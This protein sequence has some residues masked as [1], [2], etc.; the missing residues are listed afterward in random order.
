MNHSG[1]G[2]W[3][4]QVAEKPRSTSAGVLLLLRPSSL[5]RI[6]SLH[7]VYH[8]SVL[9]SNRSGRLKE[10][11]HLRAGVKLTCLMLDHQALPQIVELVICQ[12]VSKCP[13]RQRCA[14]SN[15]PT[16]VK[17][18]GLSNRYLLFL[19]DW[20]H[21]ASR[22]MISEPDLGS[23]NHASIERTSQVSWQER[24]RHLVVY[25]AGRLRHAPSCIR[26][27]EFTC[28]S[29]VVELQNHAVS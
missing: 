2:D 19:F 12:W 27:Y 25:L 8:Q 26:V 6:R 9:Q 3:Q 14:L 23:C 29:Y 10:A 5:C 28:L 24:F 11:G 22:W 20:L 21:L 7:L 15:Q 16:S 13:H 4:W 1:I 17:V 18:G